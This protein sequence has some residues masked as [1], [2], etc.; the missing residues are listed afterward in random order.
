MDFL[1]TKRIPLI[2]R[3]AVCLQEQS[4]LL[5][6]RPL[7]VMFLLATD[8]LHGLVD[9][10]RTDGESSV[11]LLPCE[12]GVTRVELFHPLAAV[13]LDGADEVG[14]RH[15][16]RQRREDVHVVG[17][18]PDFDRQPANALDDAAD[19][20]EDARKVLRPHLHAR[21]LDVEYQMNVYLYQCA[22]HI[23]YRGFTLP[24]ICHPFGVWVCC[25]VRFTGV[26]LRSTTCLWS[27]QAFG[28]LHFA[29]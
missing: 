26:P 13:G 8:V 15:R 21:A 10:R 1:I 16:L 2:I 25:V 22:C 14:K 28:L 20:G 6:E 9:E 3:N 29:V 18:A 11:S 19:I 7:L 5:L 24:V 4:I 12:R 23:V 27:C 17:D